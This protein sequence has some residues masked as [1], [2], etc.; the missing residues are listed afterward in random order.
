VTTIDIVV[1]G[2]VVVAVDS[3]DPDLRV[4]VFDYD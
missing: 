4:E 3:S 2:G 1:E